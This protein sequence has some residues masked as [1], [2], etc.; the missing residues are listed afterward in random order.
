M[1]FYLSTT[2]QR[3]INNIIDAY[4]ISQGATSFVHLCMILVNLHNS[5]IGVID[6]GFTLDTRVKSCL[7]VSTEVSYA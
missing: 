2:A 3:A 4:V 5:V 1:C 7:N 6:D